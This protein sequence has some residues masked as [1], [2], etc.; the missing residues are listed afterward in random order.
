[1]SYSYDDLLKAYSQLGVGKGRVV[2]VG[3]SLPYLR[4][5]ETPGKTAVLDAHY[6]ALMSLLGEDGTIAVFTQSTPLCNTD[7][8]FDVNETPSISGIFSEYIR[9]KKG[10]YRSFHPFSSYAAIGKR[11]REITQDV[12]RHAYGPETPMA[13]MIALDTLCISIGIPPRLTCSTIHQAELAMG[14]PYRY[15]KEFEHPVVRDGKIVNELFYLYV[16]YRECNVKRNLLVKIFEQF[17]ARHEIKSVDV[18]KGQI[19]SYSMREFY[20]CVIQLLKEDI[21]IWLN[22]IP[23]IKPYRK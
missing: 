14:V 1:M 16:W 22:E 11:A 15:V 9:K 5:F 18:G 7:T 19:Y 10:A 8:P 20:D 4:E 3:A 23:E 12:A 6:N 2:Y 17:S 21:Y 13:R